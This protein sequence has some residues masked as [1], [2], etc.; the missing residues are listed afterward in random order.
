MVTNYITYDLL[1]K[2]FIIT[3][4]SSSMIYE[5]VPLRD[6]IEYLAQLDMIGNILWKNIAMLNY[7]ATIKL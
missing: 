5:T 2:Y 7:S 4:S 6:R 3:V 1:L